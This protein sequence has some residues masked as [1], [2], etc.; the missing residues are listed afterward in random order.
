M[1]HSLCLKSG[2]SFPH[3]YSHP[4]ILLPSCLLSS[5]HP[6]S[7]M[8]TLIPSSSFPHVYSHPF[9]LLPSCLLSSLLVLLSSTPNPFIL[10][11]Y[12]HP[13]ILLYPSF[14]IP[15]H[16]PSPSFLHQY[17][18]PDTSSPQHLPST[19]IHFSSTSNIY[20]SI[21]TFKSHIAV[22]WTL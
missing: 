4:F 22:S 19:S 8:S 3:V 14:L 5:L 15:T 2:S 18:L 13:I 11:P 16:I 7:L 1:V 21:P 6:P 10:H 17:I 12:P 9:I 20:I